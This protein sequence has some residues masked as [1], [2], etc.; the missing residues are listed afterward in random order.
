MC[1]LLIIIDLGK[2]LATWVGLSLFKPY[3]MPIL[4]FIF[5]RGLATINPR[6]PIYQLLKSIL[7]ENEAPGFNSKQQFC[8]VIHNTNLKLSVLYL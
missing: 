5:H 6:D 2:M 4:Y 3:S 8:H 1:A 7:P